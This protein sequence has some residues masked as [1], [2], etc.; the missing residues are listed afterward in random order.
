MWLFSERVKTYSDPS[1]IFSGGQGPPS[2][3]GSTLLRCGT[4]CRK[5]SCR[6][7]SAGPRHV[8]TTCWTFLASPSPAP[9]SPAGTCLS[10][11]VTTADSGPRTS[12]APLYH[13][14]MRQSAAP[15][16]VEAAGAAD[17]E[18]GD[19]RW[20]RS[21]SAK[22]T[23]EKTCWIWSM[24]SGV[25]ANPPTTSYRHTP[26]L[27]VNEYHGRRSHRNWGGGHDP[28]FSRQRGM[29]GTKLTLKV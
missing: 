15:G 29:G 18:L 12:R 20:K 25:M 1:Y 14:W 3:P 13:C 11:S 27:Q 16:D 10:V 2:T 21:R 7:W 9:V 4:T 26:Q 23:R 17:G 8:I 19:G 5:K 28:H 24:Y 6:L 22:T